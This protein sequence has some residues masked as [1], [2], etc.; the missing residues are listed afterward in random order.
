MRIS[1]VPV[2]VALEALPDPQHLQ[3]WWRE[4]ESRAELTFFTSWS[5]IGQWLAV[6][7]VALHKQLLV[8]RQGE[9]IVGLGIVVKGQAHLMRTMPVRCWRL[10]ATGIRDIDDLTIEYNGFLVDGDGGGDVEQT[11]LDFLLQRSGVKRVEVAMATD[12]FTKLAQPAPKNFLVR[13]DF[14]Q[15]YLVDLEQVRA[16]GGDFLSTLSA[17]TRSQIKRSLGAYREFGELRIEA[18]QSVEQACVFFNE[19][20]TLHARVWVERGKHSRF[21]TS[22]IAQRF[23]TALIARAFDT[24]EVQL[25]RVTAGASVLGYLYNFV[26]RGRVIF[27]QSGFNYGLLDK[28]DRPGMVCHTL[29]VQHQLQAGHALYDLA[30]GDYRYKAS[31]AKHYEIQGSHVFQQGGLLPRLDASMR[32]VLGRVR[33]WRASTQLVV[34]ALGGLHMAVAHNAHWCTDYL[35]T[36]SA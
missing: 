33:K 4:L 22:P 17:N 23:H 18:A 31:L 19:L 29:A 34:G 25:L 2:H 1:P 35:M 7:P 28:H 24:G 3:A 16:S 32:K 36:V 11:M 6:L 27:Y 13:S 15:S 8:A 20:K 30:A 5:W 12:R 21:A 14:K 26:Y 10:H 9:R